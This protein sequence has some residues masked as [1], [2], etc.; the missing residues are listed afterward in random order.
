MGLTCRSRAKTTV[1]MRM[2]CCLD[3]QKI[4]AV[5]NM[6]AP[7]N[8]TTLCFFLGL[9]NYYQPFTPNMCSIHQPLDDLPKKDNEWKWSTR[10]Q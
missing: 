10:C 8:I 9:V 7:T 3:P 4:T 6:P 2:G 5:A 1:L